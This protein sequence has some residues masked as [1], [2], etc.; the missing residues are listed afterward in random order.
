MARL[1]GY[2]EALMNGDLTCW[3]RTKPKIWALFDEPT[4]SNGAKVNIHTLKINLPK[5]CHHDILY[6][7]CNVTW[8]Q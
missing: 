5:I 3:Q 4:S 2:E 6:R 1:F 7:P 8:N